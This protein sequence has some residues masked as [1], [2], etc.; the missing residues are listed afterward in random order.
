[1]QAIQTDRLAI[2]NFR[3]ED[4]RDLHEMIVQ[5]QASEYAQYDQKWPTAEEAIQGV[6]KW[7]AEGD[8]YLAACLRTT[9][10]LIGFVAVNRR[11][12]PEYG[13][14]VNLGYVFNFGYHGQGYAT[15]ACRAAIEHAFERLGVERMVTGTAHENLPS[16]RLL[17]R[18]GFRELG[19][20]LYVLTRDEWLAQRRAAYGAAS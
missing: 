2:R 8:S 6:A 17:A 9:G 14:A 11:E 20:G 18:L 16:R 12:E 19:D 15:E 1:M 5:Y 10:K 3:P 4:W 7:F 13:S